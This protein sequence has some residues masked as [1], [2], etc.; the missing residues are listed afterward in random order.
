MFEDDPPPLPSTPSIENSC[1]GT[2]ADLN[3]QNRYTA[4]ADDD[5]NG[6]DA[7][8]CSHMSTVFQTQLDPE[9]VS[10]EMPLPC[11]EFTDANQTLNCAKKIVLHN[12]FDEQQKLSSYSLHSQSPQFAQIT[13]SRSSPSETISYLGNLDVI[14]SNVTNHSI[15][16]DTSFSNTPIVLS[17]VSVDNLPPALIESI[18]EDRIITNDSD[19]IQAFGIGKKDSFLTEITKNGT[20]GSSNLRNVDLIDES[21]KTVTEQSTLQSE[22]L[23]EDDDEFGDFEEFAGV[24]G[25]QK[26]ENDSWANFET[27]SLPDSSMKNKLAGKITSSGGKLQFVVENSVMPEL[28]ENLCDDQLWTTVAGEGENSD[29]HDILDNELY[30]TLNDI[31]NTKDS[32]RP[33]KMVWI[34]VS[35]IEEALALKL[36]WHDSLIRS[37]FLCSL[38]VDINQTVIRNSDL[39]VFAQQLEENAVL[40]PLSVVDNCTEVTLVSEKNSSSVS[41]Q[42]P[43]KSV[44]IDSLAVPPVQFDWNNSGL[45]NPL[46]AGSLNVSSASLELDFLASTS[47]KGSAGDGSSTIQ[48]FSALEKD[49]TTF[50]LSLPNDAGK[51]KTEKD[52]SSNTPIVLDYLMNKNDSKQKYKPVS[53]LSLDARALHDQLPDLDYMLSNVLLFPIV[54]R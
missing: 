52:V 30:E 10:S 7:E 41:Q 6:I 13:K 9:F 50:G 3:D 37:C 20:K 32:E 4:V 31:I 54:D 22:P 19:D 29:R 46:K 28:L 21:E 33:D 51:S 38:G 36:Q 43:L 17:N 53:E 44:T 47:N 11:A 8:F 24:K 42:A 1:D 2:F 12:E 45:T 40:T 26:G 49:L 27:S 39:P 5:C 15:H 14:N 16:V 34:A 35:V 25:T 18:H 23:N 48:A